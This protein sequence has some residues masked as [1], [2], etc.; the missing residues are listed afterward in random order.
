MTSKTRGP[1]FHAWGFCGLLVLAGA[2]ASADV[3]FR[4]GFEC[5]LL[6]PASIGCEFYAVP[7][8]NT[9]LPPGNHFAVVLTNPTNRR[10]RAVVSG[11]PLPA[12]TEVFVPGGGAAFAGGTYLPWVAAL[13]TT[14]ASAHVTNGAY[15][16]VS[17]GPLAAH[18]FNSFEPS[19][20]ADAS[21]LLPVAALS[22]NYDVV[23]WPSWM[24]YP[25]YLAVVGTEDG[26][27]VTLNTS[28]GTLSTSGQAVPAASVVT[29]ILNRGDVL[30]V[31]AQTGAQQDVSGSSITA[32]KPVAVFAGHNVAPVPD[33]VCCGDHL[34]EQMPPKE[35]LG[36]DFVVAV[37]RHDYGPH[38]HY[39]KL[40]GAEDG[41][42]LTYAPPLAGVP[43]TLEAGAAVTF[44]ATQDFRLTANKPLTVAQFLES[45]AQF[46]GPGNGGDPS[47]G[48]VVP[49]TQFLR[50][51]TFPTPWDSTPVDMNTWVTI[52]APTGA[53]VTLD[54][55]AVSPAS[56]T[57]V[58]GTPYAIARVTVNA[59]SA[60]AHRISAT[61]PVGVYVYAYGGTVSHLFP[62]GMGLATLP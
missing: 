42:V 7:L 36:T 44:E 5:D 20:T 4:D 39:V 1:E 55:V 19:G 26:T 22:G 59:R 56:F 14:G 57:A 27:E 24:T 50:D 29:A 12:P 6:P 9:L 31:M 21:L 40:V 38:R 41:T 15:H 16:I 23:S 3:I 18:Q 25:G 13:Q 11:G 30:Q 53:V 34:E 32:D 54:E 35:T 61:A 28:T 37:P 2:S 46:F 8:A 33:G 45:A 51:Y 52:V 62:A 48:T 60:L 49:S 58:S 43:T 10:A 17:D 47:L